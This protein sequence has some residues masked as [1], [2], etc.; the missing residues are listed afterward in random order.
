[1]TVGV[2]Y[3]TEDRDS[4]HWLN[5]SYNSHSEDASVLQGFAE[6][7]YNFDLGAA[8]VSPYV[9]FTWAHVKSDGFTETA[10]GVQFTTQDQKDDLQIS[11]LGVRTSLPFNWGTLPVAVKADLGW[12]HFYGD[13]DAVTRLQLGAN[14]GIA[15]LTS[16]ELKD[17]FNLGLGIVGQVAKNA[18]VGVSYTGAFGSDTDTHG[19]IGTFRLAF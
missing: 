11:T 5:G 12:S 9:G 2:A 14:G 4:S 17:Q 3:T 8:K 10:G 16:N 19:I 7:A 18:T 6:A 13:T 15:E 1:M